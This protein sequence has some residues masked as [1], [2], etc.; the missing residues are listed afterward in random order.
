MN[1]MNVGITLN[2]ENALR[3]ISALMSSMSAQTRHPTPIKAIHEPNMWSKP[4]LTLMKSHESANT[5]GSCMQSNSYT[6]ESIGY[7]IR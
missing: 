5:V 3:V 4:N 7:K 2:G 6:N 1:Q